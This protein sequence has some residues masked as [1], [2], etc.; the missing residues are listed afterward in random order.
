MT[1]K[2][3][4]AVSQN[5]IIGNKELNNLPWTMDEYK[6]DMAFFRRMTANSTIIMGRNTF[7][8]I[9][10]KPLPKRRNIVVTSQT[11]TIPNIELAHSLEEAIGLAHQDLD[12]WIIGGSSIYLAG[13]KYA[14]EIYLTLVPKLIT[15]SADSVFFPWINP[16]LFEF[17]GSMRLEG[18]NN[19]DVAK[20]SKIT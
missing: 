15:P 5:G 12:V 6:E 7:T 16:A 11:T 4:A 1:I 18:D 19:L 8:S 10:S 20:Y 2:M 17:K 14:D 13:M 3:I 9:G